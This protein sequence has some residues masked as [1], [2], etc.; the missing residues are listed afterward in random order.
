MEYIKRERSI[1]REGSDDGLIASGSIVFASGDNL[2]TEKLTDAIDL[3]GK[4]I[5]PDATFLL[6]IDKPTENTAGN[7]TVKTYNQVKV[8]DTNE[9]SV[10]H[11]THTVDVVTGAASYRDFLIQGLFIGEGTIKIGMSFA[12]DSGAITV[13]YKLYRIYF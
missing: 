3:L 10:L 11:A 2:T 6:V 9:R 5:H 8:D 7:L 13:Y 12:T 1:L 4:G